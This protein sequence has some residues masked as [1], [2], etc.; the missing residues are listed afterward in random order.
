M[1]ITIEKS[2]F[3]D[4]ILSHL[5]VVPDYLLKDVKKK[6]IVAKVQNNAPTKRKWEPKKSS[7][8]SDPLKTFS[9]VS[10][11][12][13]IWLRLIIYIYFRAEKKKNRLKCCDFLVYFEA[14]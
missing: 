11:S 10:F 1:I 3:H 12:F 14:I 9:F 7:K 8:Q 6:G 13:H 2:L 4:H 5:R